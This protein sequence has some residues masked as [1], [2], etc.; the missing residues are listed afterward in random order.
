MILQSLLQHSRKP[1]WTVITDLKK[2][3]LQDPEVQK[4]LARIILE[5]GPNKDLG[6]GKQILALIKSMPRN[7]NVRI[8]ENWSQAVS[9]HQSFLSKTCMNELNKISSID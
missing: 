2:L 8:K 6:L 7:L 4:C 1:D 5:Q 9:L 3:D